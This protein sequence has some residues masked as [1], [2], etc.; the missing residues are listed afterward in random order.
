MSDDGDRVTVCSVMR[1][2]GIPSS[3]HRGRRV[4]WM[5]GAA[6]RDKWRAQ[7]DGERP[8]VRL[9]A[10]S[11]GHGTHDKATYPPEWRVIVVE[12][13]EKAAAAVGCTDRA[14]QLRL[15]RG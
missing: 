2:L 3:T 11:N 6:V 4:A 1:D 14:P 8:E 9:V 5:A 15:F 12:Q 13:I 7:H 10:K